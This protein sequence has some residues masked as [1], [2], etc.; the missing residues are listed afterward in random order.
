VDGPGSASSER[1]LRR[2]RFDNTA[3]QLA[4]DTVFDAMLATVDRRHRLD[5][6]IAEMGLLIQH[7][8]RW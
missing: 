1:W 7:S 4:Y 3:L 5:A 6:A 2:Q 8:P